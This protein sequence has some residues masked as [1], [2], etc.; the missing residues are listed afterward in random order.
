MQFKLPM[1]F[2]PHLKRSVFAVLLAAAAAASPRAEAANILWV[3]DAGV[4]G[5]FGPA[6]SNFTDSAFVSLLQAAGHNVT[7]FN[8]SNNSA[9]ALSPTELAAI[10][11]NDLIIAGRGGASGSWQNQR[12]TNWNRD[13]IRPLIVMSPYFVRPDGNRLGWFTGGTLP[14]DVPSP[15]T[16]ATSGH[17]IV[18]YLFNGVVMNGT[19]TLALFDEP[20]DRNTSHIQNAPVAG[21]IPVA[22]ITGPQEANVAVV[23]VNAITAFPVGTVVGGGIALPAF[24]MYFSGGSR[25]SATAP[26]LVQFYAGR[27]NLTPM[28]EQVFLRAVELALNNGIA[29][30]TNVGPAAITSQPTN[31]SVAFGANARFD[32]TVA[33]AA[34][35]TLQW[36]RISEDNVTFTNIP[37]T[38]TAFTRSALVLSNVTTA[39][40]GARFRAVVDNGNGPVV[41]DEVTLT[42][43]PDTTAPIAISAGTLD[44]RTVY[45]CYNERVDPSVATEIS[46]YQFDGGSGPNI[47]SIGLS[48]DGKMVTMSLSAPLN[49]TSTLDVLNT[50]D[51]QGN[52]SGDVASFVLQNPGLQFADIGTLSP[53]GT[54]LTC[55]ASNVFQVTGGGLDMG[56]TSDTL[57]FVFKPV[58]GNFDARVRVTDFVGTSDHFET[59]AKAALVARVDNSAGSPMATVFATPL[60]P[61]DSTIV[62]HARLTAGGATNFLGTAPYTSSNAWLRIRRVD[63][64]ITTFRSHDGTNWVSFGTVSGFTAP[65]M[66]VGVGVVSRRNGKTVTAT[67][68]KFTIASVVVPTVLTNVAHQS[69]VFSAAFATQPNVSYT[70]EFKNDIA[71]PT[72][73]TLTNIVGDGELKTFG[74]STDSPTGRRFYRVNAQ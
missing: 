53:A 12:A 47:E 69:G 62:S 14:D 65:T 71:T 59:L 7:R 10:N 33:G 16:P 68:E 24:R 45:V 19:N 4:P 37:G 56:S 11:T 67:F 60:A 52:G 74:D 36:Q 32:V 44:G 66:N 55:A 18:D 63:N 34:P 27:E 38:L 39:D 61:G 8:A 57:R 51:P 17:P 54:N 70:V 58:T 41:S 20:M 42:V 9:V 21:A 43:I 28:G 72:W 48:A 46:T 15:L 25:E 5:T 23:T 30:V 2:I 29:P 73:N 26:N 6:G 13:V 50:A 1:Q 49:A 64:Q 22:T 35:R 40:N 31:A 3:S